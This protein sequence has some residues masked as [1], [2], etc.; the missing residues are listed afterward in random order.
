MTEEPQSQRHV[1]SVTSAEL[2]QVTLEAPILN[3]ESFDHHELSAC[4]RGA[5]EK[6]EQ[7]GRPDEAMVYKLIHSLLDM[8]FKP[9]DRAEPFGPNFV[10]DGRRSLI[11][12]DIPGELAAA[13][14]NHASNLKHPVLRARIADIAWIV[15]RRL[16]AVAATAIG[17]YCESVEA[18][19]AGTLDPRRTIG[20]ATDHETVE[21][22]RRAC[23]IA[24]V[25]KGKNP[26]PP[27]LA[28]LVA[29][30][31][32]DAFGRKYLP[33]FSQAAV[34]DLDFDITPAREIA[35][36]GEAIVEGVAAKGDGH[37]PLA[38]LELSSRAYRD[39]GD[40]DNQNRLTVKAA[41]FCVSCSETFKTVPML[42]AHWL[43][44]AIGIL[45]RGRSA[46]V[47]RNELRKRLIDVQASTLDDFAPIG[48]SIDI[49]DIVEDVR[50]KISGKPLAKVLY[51]L[52]LAS[53][54]PAPEELRADADAR[55]N[56]SLASIFSTQVLDNQGKVKFQSPGLSRKE[57]GDNET[58]LRFEIMQR[59]GLR[60]GLVVKSALELARAII[61]A[62]HGITTE[63]LLPLLQNS[64]F[65]QP[66][67]EYVFAQG[68]AR[69]F[70]GDI[71]SAA[72]I[73][74][75]QLE[76]ALR[77]ILRNAGEDVSTM[78]NDGTQEDR[79][80]TSMFEQMRPEI[81][82]VMGEAIPYEIENLF[83]LRAGPNVRHAIA[84]GQYSAGHFFADDASYACWF[85]FQLCFMPLIRD[86]KNVEA[87][88]DSL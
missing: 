25:T 61:N 12:Q 49:S 59:E 36:Q 20:D 79:S 21:R 60:R 52:V 24:V 43:T 55:A 34:L 48:T 75:P 26:F 1:T 45:G 4:Y 13:L 69:W 6:S 15:N 80:I 16:A 14:G 47:R 53:K 17:G 73:L 62:E 46:K 18:L 54:S 10:F 40:T 29:E 32:N 23:Q 31:R 63:K 27:R 8:H 83:L 37:L 72:S 19:R 44:R 81:V 2:D 41:E 22:L 66:G 78:K 71:I 33:G 57:G 70:N 3:C 7:E 65:V 58:Q 87:Y 64:P 88:L 85:I 76:N 50:T 11:P 30:T 56:N 38:I 42:E 84:H 39:A 35:Q 51:S 28:A 5:A 9:V 86:W 74:V 77:Y 68:F 67:H 82:R